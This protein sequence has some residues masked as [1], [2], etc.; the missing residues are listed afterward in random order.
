M[1]PVAIL[2]LRRYQQHPRQICHQ[3]RLSCW[4]RWQI[5]HRCPQFHPTN[6]HFITIRFY[7]ISSLQY[8]NF[9]TGALG[10]YIYNMHFCSVLLWY[11]WYL[12]NTMNEDS[13]SRHCFWNWI[14]N[15]NKMNSTTLQA[16]MDDQ[17]INFKRSIKHL[18]KHCWDVQNKA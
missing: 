14:K 13:K 6:Y 16:K 10:T 4:H 17:K 5:F 11:F 18:T 12:V 8:F 1:T 15:P 2:P 9:S 7:I 3:F